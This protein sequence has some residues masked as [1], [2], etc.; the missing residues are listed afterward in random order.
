MT[1]REGR[2]GFCQLDVWSCNIDL[3]L[4]LLLMGAPDVLFT[5]TF[6]VPLKI[7]RRARETPDRTTARQCALSWGQAYVASY[8]PV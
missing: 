7:R 1:R 2:A 5:F 4:N 8:Y 3:P 6:P